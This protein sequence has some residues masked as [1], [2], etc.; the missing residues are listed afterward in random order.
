MRAICPQLEEFCTIYLSTG[1]EVSAFKQTFAGKRGYVAKTAAKDAR[2]FLFDKN[3]AERLALMSRE[4]LRMKRL[5]A[6]AVLERIAQMA[7]ADVTE[8][9]KLRRVNCRYCWG[10]KFKRQATQAEYEDACTDAFVAAQMAGKDEYEQPEPPPGGLG[11]RANRPPH[12]DCPEC[13]GEGHEEVFLQDFDKLS[14]DVKPLIAGVEHTRYGVKVLF[15]DQAKSLETLAKCFGL[16]QPDV[17]IQIIQQ[18]MP[19]RGATIVL[20]EQ[21]IQKAT[22]A[23]KRLLDGSN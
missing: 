11:F 22:E 1:D 8:A 17:A 10:T 23:Y 9:V 19:N 21:N 14:D 7:F 18:M 13:C 5:D 20:D 12:P 16:M 6:Q 15:H 2:A 4:A 3:V